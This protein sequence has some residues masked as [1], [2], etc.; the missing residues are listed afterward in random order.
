[1]LEGQFL[2]DLTWSGIRNPGRRSASLWRLKTRPSTV[3]GGVEE[4]G[5]AR[6]GG[7]ARSK[8]RGFSFIAAARHLQSDRVHT[9][10]FQF[11]FFKPGLFFLFKT[12]RDFCL[13][14]TWDEF[15]HN[16]SWHKGVQLAFVTMVLAKC[17]ACLQVSRPR[18]REER[19]TVDGEVG[20]SPH[21]GTL[22]TH[23]NRDNSEFRL[24]VCQIS[25]SRCF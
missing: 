12:G 2:A 13:I 10:V 5:G 11:F 7:G 9:D 8:Q 19:W 24:F 3:N 4:Y 6:N 15:F 21:E 22:E 1:M 18:N 25:M 17:D 14:R 16:V 20:L 23:Y